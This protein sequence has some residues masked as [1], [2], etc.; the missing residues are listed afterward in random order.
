M[1]YGE[2]VKAL[3]I[4]QKI[5]EKGEQTRGKKGE[6][7]FP[8]ASQ[9]LIVYWFPEPASFCK[10]HNKYFSLKVQYMLHMGA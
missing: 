5:R 7:A 6:Q 2:K 3:C 4:E 9:R 1:G 8:I 10:S